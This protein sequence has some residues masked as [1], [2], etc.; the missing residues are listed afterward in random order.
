MDSCRCK[1]SHISSAMAEQ[2]PETLSVSHSQPTKLATLPTEPPQGNA[3]TSSKRTHCTCLQGINSSKASHNH[4]TACLPF[5]QQLHS[6]TRWHLHRE[7]HLPAVLAQWVPQSTLR[8]AATADV[9]AGAGVSSIIKLPHH[10]A[11]QQAIRQQRT[12]G[13]CNSAARHAVSG[14]CHGRHITQDSP[15][16]APSS[17]LTNR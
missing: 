14:P 13:G 15:F 3:P 1:S 4:K 10:L 8:R 9:G 11:H 5:V 17:S 6:G 2:Y 12:C 16:V 7:H